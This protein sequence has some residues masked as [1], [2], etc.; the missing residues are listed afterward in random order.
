MG[1]K[2]LPIAIP[3]PIIQ[4]P[5]KSVAIE[6]DERMI[7][8]NEISVRAIINEDS[9]PIFLASPEDIGEKRAKASKGRVVNI[10]ACVD[11]K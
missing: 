7:I 5:K 3:I 10:P 11:D 2:T 1:N 4:V 6:P 9:R 8:P